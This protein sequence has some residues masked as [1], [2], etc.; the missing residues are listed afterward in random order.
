MWAGLVF[1]PREGA[2]DN[3]TLP[4]TVSY[5][6]RINGSYLPST[7]TAEEAVTRNY[8]ASTV[9]LSYVTSGF[10]SLQLAVNRAILAVKAE[11]AGAIVQQA[12]ADDGNG[13]PAAQSTSAASSV[14]AS[15][16]SLSFSLSL[17]PTRAYLSD[18]FSSLLVSAGPLYLVIGFFPLLQHLTLTLVAEV[19]GRLPSFVA[20]AGYGSS[21]FL[22]AYYAAYSVLTLVPLLFMC[23]F[24]LYYSTEHFERASLV[25]LLVL[26]YLQSL[27]L[28]G[29]VVALMARDGRQAAQLSSALMLFLLFPSFFVSPQSG[30]ASL[31]VLSLSSPVAF[32]LGFQVLTAAMGPA[33]NAGRV[34]DDLSMSSFSFTLIMLC[35]DCILYAAL[36][37]ALVRR[38]ATAARRLAA[39]AARVVDAVAAKAG[40]SGEVSLELMPMRRTYEASTSSATSS[41]SSSALFPSPDKPSAT[42]SASLRPLPTFRQ[43]PPSSTPLVSV[44]SLTHHYAGAA[45]GATRFAVAGTLAIVSVALPSSV[46]LEPPAAAVPCGRRAVVSVVLPPPR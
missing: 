25:F 41:S 22:A 10:L 4:L 37:A 19:E 16:P 14:F 46:L 43:P 40:R 35:V 5:S 9:S 31:L 33:G 17:Y 32:S 3:A 18:L 34:V 21:A 15:V 23:L 7:Y 20:K 29:V 11:Q 38:Q 24:G 39:T 12:A 42:L 26:L 8:Q 44:T 28:L 27:L 2:G 30:A 1:A 36:I 6:I 13:S 45:V